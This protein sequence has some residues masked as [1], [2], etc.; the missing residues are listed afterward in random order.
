MR[1]V[2]QLLFQSHSHQENNLTLT[3]LMIYQV[4]FLFSL[5]LGSG[6]LRFSNMKNFLSVQEDK[7]LSN[8]ISSMSCLVIVATTETTEEAFQLMD[9]MN[10]MHVKHKHLHIRLSSGLEIKE[11]ENKNIN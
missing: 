8:V 5:D 11:L 6:I 1:A 2:T 9:F 3:K 4:T 10:G 7:R